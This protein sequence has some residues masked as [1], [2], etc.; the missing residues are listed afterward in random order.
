MHKPVR[1]EEDVFWADTEWQP[2]YESRTY[3]H[4]GMGPS[5]FG[6]RDVCAKVN[7]SGTLPFAD[8]GTWM[9]R[10][11]SAQLLF[12]I[13]VG[14]TVGEMVGHCMEA[15]KI[16]QVWF[17]GLVLV[18]KE[19]ELFWTTEIELGPKE[20]YTVSESHPAVQSVKERTERTLCSLGGDQQPGYWDGGH[21]AVLKM[22][23]HAPFVLHHAGPSKATIGRRCS[24]SYAAVFIDK[25]ERWLLMDL[26]ARSAVRLGLRRMSG[27]HHFSVAKRIA[28]EEAENAAA[29]LQEWEQD[30]Q[31]GKRSGMF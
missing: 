5:L 2:L 25:H 6:G 3:G 24:G 20:G 10:V 7:D 17:P 1:K 27:H 22:G 26:D 8:S 13:L 9:G 15:L 29:L 4:S 28:D 30:Y 11:G 18:D 21:P 19:A 16:T 12:G 31:A 23:A 14:V